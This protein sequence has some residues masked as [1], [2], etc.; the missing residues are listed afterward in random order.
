[1]GPCGLA[2]THLSWC[3]PRSGEQPPALGDH[4][5]PRYTFP[6]LPVSIVTESKNA[7]VYIA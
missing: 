2:V 7:L 5:N 1:M 4:P 6:G 3:G